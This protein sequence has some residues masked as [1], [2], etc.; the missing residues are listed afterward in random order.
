MRDHP[1]G[2]MIELD[3]KDTQLHMLSLNYQNISLPEIHAICDKV[4]PDLVFLQARPEPY[5]QGF[6]LLPKVNNCFS[7]LRYF[8]QLCLTHKAIESSILTA[9][10]T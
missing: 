2:S 4:S 3:Y 8:Q 1:N 6:N 5:V 9:P 10:L 7:D